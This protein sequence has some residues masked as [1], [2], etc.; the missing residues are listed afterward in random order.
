MD[1]TTY[2]SNDQSLTHPER[3]SAQR[4]ALIQH[5]RALRLAGRI[6]QAKSKMEDLHRLALEQYISTAVRR[7]NHSICW[8]V[9]IT[10][11]GRKHFLNGEK[12]FLLLAPICTCPTLRATNSGCKL[13][14]C[15][16]R[17][18]KSS[19]LGRRTT[20]HG[21]VGTHARLDGSDFL[22]FAASLPVFFLRKVWF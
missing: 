20:Q 10:R 1:A 22:C 11:I 2:G 14:V 7:A 12:T 18:R 5:A 16:C 6:S 8:S 21:Q 19:A 13:D 4:K 3:G 17:S 9:F 15:I